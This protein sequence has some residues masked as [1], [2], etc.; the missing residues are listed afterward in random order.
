MPLS[1]TLSTAEQK[2]DEQR[3]KVN[4]A[5]DN[6]RARLKAVADDAVEVTEGGVEQATSTLMEQV[7]IWRERSLDDLGRFNT[8][9]VDATTS[10]A[11]R[12]PRAELP[13][14]GKLPA[15]D[16]L[17]GDG[18]DYAIALAKLQKQFALDLVAAAQTEAPAEKKASNK[19]A[20]PKAA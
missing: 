9:V 7:K 13:F 19:K 1:E 5:F 15:A 10:V 4:E 8:I 2:L 3:A 11:K 12:V 18:F 14:S 6:G 17:I 20:A 16:Q